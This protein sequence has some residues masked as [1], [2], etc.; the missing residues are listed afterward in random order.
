MG[1]SRRTA[2]IA[3]RESGAA[4]RQRGGEMLA[5]KWSGT[6]TRLSDWETKDAQEHVDANDCRA[7]LGARA[8]KDRIS[9]ATSAASRPLVPTMNSHVE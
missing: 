1:I 3:A 2:S 9:F 8:I 6:S 4:P 7:Q 5:P